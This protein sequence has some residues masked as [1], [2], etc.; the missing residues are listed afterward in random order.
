MEDSAAVLRSGQ[1][2]CNAGD[3]AEAGKQSAE[4]VTQNDKRRCHENDTGLLL[5]QSL[6]E[7]I[8]NGIL[9]EIHG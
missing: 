7:R 3:E 4:T 6:S 5:F 8:Y 1:Q 9:S 2:L